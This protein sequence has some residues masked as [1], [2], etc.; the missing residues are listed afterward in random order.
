MYQEVPENAPRVNQHIRCCNSA[1]LQ[2]CHR[3]RHRWLD[4]PR[5]FDSSNLFAEGKT[6]GRVED[7]IEWLSDGHKKKEPII[8]KDTANPILD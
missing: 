4:A 5:S 8:E 7:N 1:L 2:W 6:L 3:P